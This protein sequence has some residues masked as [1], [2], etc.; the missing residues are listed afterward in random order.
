MI[1]QDLPYGASLF[2]D[3]NTFVYH[4]APDPVSDSIGRTRDGH[5]G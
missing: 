1:F 2:L 4:F 3:A 5:V